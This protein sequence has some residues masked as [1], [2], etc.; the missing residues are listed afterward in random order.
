MSYTYTGK[1]KPKPRITPSQDCIDS[2]L[3]TPV[4]WPLLLLLFLFSPFIFSSE[5]SNTSP[6][7][8]IAGLPHVL[9]QAI[10]HDGLESK[11][12]AS[13]GAFQ[14]PASQK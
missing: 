13:K 5:I 11:P 8:H 4:F 9:S 3:K 6:T 1:Q 2:P 10:S 12:L 7:I 14:D